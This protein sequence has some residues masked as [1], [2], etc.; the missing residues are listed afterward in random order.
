MNRNIK[1]KNRLGKPTTWIMATLLSAGLYFSA[2]KPAIADETSDSKST[3][4]TQTTSVSKLSTQELSKHIILGIELGIIGAFMILTW[5][6][7]ASAKRG[8]VAEPLSSGK[9]S[10]NIDYKKTLDDLFKDIQKVVEDHGQSKKELETALRKIFNEA[11]TK[12]D[13]GN[14]MGLKTFAA[15]LTKLL[16]N[17][18]LS[19]LSATDFE[20]HINNMKHDFGVFKNNNK[21]KIFFF[22]LLAEILLPLAGIVSTQVALVD[23]F[24]SD[25][26]DLVRVGKAIL[27][28]I[29]GF[30]SSAL[31]Q[32]SFG[33]KMYKHFEEAKQRLQHIMNMY[34]LV[35]KKTHEITQESKGK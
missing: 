7:S 34:V 25:S 19:K 35:S 13:D 12:M 20:F 24:S 29:V 10:L 31:F 30:T 21:S 26:R 17:K 16:T 18:D 23:M 6:Q 9:K 32:Y 8:L 1:S 15:E 33:K 2:L 11:I 4:T 3:K 28:P 27:P 22:R 14:S 5:V